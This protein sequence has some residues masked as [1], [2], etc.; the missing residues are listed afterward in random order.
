MIDRL[1]RIARAISGLALP[2]L[3]LAAVLFAYAVFI[4]LTSSSHAGDRFLFPSILGFAWALSLYGFIETFRQ[5]PERP[6]RD[7]GLW[8]RTGRKLARFWY[9]LIAVAFF[10]ASSAVL[11][12][13]LRTLSVWFGS[14][15]AEDG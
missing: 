15:P 1:Q 6:G 10:V 13:S 2:S 14:Y 3:A 5:V 4:V 11:V 12:L 9:G 7:A 8:R